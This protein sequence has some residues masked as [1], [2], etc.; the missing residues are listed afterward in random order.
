[1][2]I[3]KRHAACFLL[4]LP[5]T[6]VFAVNDCQHTSGLKQLNEHL[7]QS[8]E[9]DLYHYWYLRIKHFNEFMLRSFK[10]DQQSV[11]DLIWSKQYTQAQLK[12]KLVQKNQNIFQDLN[13]QFVKT[14]QQQQAK[15]TEL[16]DVYHYFANYEK[17]LEPYIA[18]QLDKQQKQ[19][20]MV[21][22]AQKDQAINALFQYDIQED[23]LLKQ[24]IQQNFHF[25][26]TEIKTLNQ[27]HDQDKRIS[28]CQMKL[29]L[30]QQKSVILEYAIGQFVDESDVLLMPTEFKVNRLNV[31]YEDIGHYLIVQ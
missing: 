27:E 9:N 8:I 6:S 19:L 17:L 2:K 1:M 7:N 21:Y 25:K 23:K 5:T 31:G 26:F 22:D 10:Q 30:N 11:N 12:Q 3:I 16:D 18:M 24:Q 4:L 28:Y 15:E 13:T 20:L 14:A 29:M